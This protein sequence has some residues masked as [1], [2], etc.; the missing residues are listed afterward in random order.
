MSRYL[1]ILR[2]HRRVAAEKLAKLDA[3]IEAV[4]EVDAALEA[5]ESPPPEKASA[6]QPPA[7]REPS[8]T[9]EN[10]STPSPR[11]SA[12]DVA[13]FERAW[14]G[15]AHIGEVATRIGITSSCAQQRAARLR[16]LGH[17]LKRFSKGCRRPPTSA[18][19]TTPAD[20]RGA[21]LRFDDE[22][23]TLTFPDGTTKQF[24]TIAA[25]RAYAESEAAKLGVDLSIDDSDDEDQEP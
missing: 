3:A 20:E 17:E 16:A 22:T 6:K 21:E 25:G 15:A 13:A 12:Y 1:E 5:D 4:A 9:V 24:S 14:N 23:R 7:R 19:P 18:G 8:R 2:E 10:R 11:G